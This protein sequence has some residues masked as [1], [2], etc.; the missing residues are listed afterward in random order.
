MDSA[1]I[2]A[3][4]H[5]RTHARTQSTIYARDVSKMSLKYGNVL[6]MS[7]GHSLEVFAVRIY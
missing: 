7:L 1:Y 5:A 4:T 6:W 2:Q 3:R